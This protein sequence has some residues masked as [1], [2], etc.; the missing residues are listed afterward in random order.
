MGIKACS[1]RTVHEHARCV[2]TDVSS[3][4]TN[5]EQ[6]NLYDPVSQHGGRFDLNI[7]HFLSF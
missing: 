7:L 3:F 5:D 6:T 4:R 1:L 2:Y